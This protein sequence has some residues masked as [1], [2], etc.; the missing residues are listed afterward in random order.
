M[1]HIFGAA[2]EAVR[3]ERILQ[4][5]LRWEHGRSH[6]RAAER[7]LGRAAE[8]KLVFERGS[9]C[10]QL[11][12]PAP[13]GRLRIIAIGKASVSMAKGAI[14]ALAKNGAEPGH[15][16]LD[17]ADCQGLIIAKENALAASWPG[18][19]WQQIE[20]GHPLA[21]ARSVRAG[22]TLLRF[23]AHSRR[24]DRYLILLSGGASALAVQPVPGITL[25]EKSACVQ[26]LMAQGAPISA[27]NLLRR[28]LSMLKGGGL[29][30][31]L[32]PALP[33][34][35]AIA[36]VPGDDPAV[37]GSAPTWDVPRDPLAVELI[38]KEFNLW[39]Q[40]QAVLAP[41]LWADP[42]SPVSE[43]APLPPS[44]YVV[45]A[46]LNDA[47]EAAQVAAREADLAPVNLGRV[48]YDDVMLHVTQFCEAIRQC[49]A[50]GPTAGS[51]LIA[52]GEPTL[53]ITG[54]GAG[55]GGR[56]QHFALACARALQGMQGVAVLAAGTDGTDGPTPVAGAVI[57]GDSWLAMQRA[58]I[59]PERALREYDSYRAL[60]AI[61]AH[62]H[63]GDTGT[64]VADLFLAVVHPVG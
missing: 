53:R 11:P 39:Q 41:V 10:A 6:E 16:Q 23:V 28:H 58:G 25:A 30:R 24:E 19:G 4:Q 29:A 61:G 35:L 15:S 59:D 12:G 22:E 42:V 50:Q 36:D 33:L 47:I 55:R 14:T 20:G 37:I 3:G 49:A 1:E 57:D 45:I 38:L 44:P 54:V 60:Q 21:D 17:M 5:G 43:Q 64:N 26:A 51:L 13:G 48:F 40:W 31:A 62:I 9:A 2:I 8:P 63:T 18:V 46:T 52:A 34:T 27:L 7:Q 32:A 56:A